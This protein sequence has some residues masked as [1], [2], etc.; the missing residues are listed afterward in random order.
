LRAQDDLLELLRSICRCTEA[1]ALNP[2]SGAL[3]QLGVLSG[4]YR[5]IDL[6]ILASAI[7]TPG[8]KLE[9]DGPDRGHFRFHLI[10]QTHLEMSR[11]VG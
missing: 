1:A 8:T 6:L 3:W 2:S 11:C 9:N 10:V 7:P 5:C 4:D